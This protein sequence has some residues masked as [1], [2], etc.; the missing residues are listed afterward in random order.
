MTTAS[1]AHA[2]NYT[3]LPPSSFTTS[4][5]LVRARDKLWE[6]GPPLGWVG[7]DFYTRWK[8][9]PLH[10]LLQTVFCRIIVILCLSMILLTRWHH[11]F[12]PLNGLPDATRGLVGT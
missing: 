5:R 10:A 8:N 7:S 6:G 11:A 2:T 3:P 9:R 12:H 4:H 1:C